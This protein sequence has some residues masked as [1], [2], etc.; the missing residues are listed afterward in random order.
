MPCVFGTLRFGLC[1]KASALHRVAKPLREARTFVAEGKPRGTAEP[2]EAGMRPVT[3]RYCL[4]RAARATVFRA[5][6]NV[7]NFYNNC[8]GNVTRNAMYM[9]NQSGVDVGKKNRRLQVR[10][11]NGRT[12]RDIKKCERAGIGAALQRIKSGW[13]F[14]MAILFSLSACISG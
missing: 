11:E 8:I 6:S 7:G 2:D 5:K 13:D 12:I 10:E 4:A 3:A 9:E 14:S 1:R